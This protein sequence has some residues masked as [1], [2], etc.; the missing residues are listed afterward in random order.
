MNGR[1]RAKTKIGGAFKARNRWRCKR[2]IERTGLEVVIRFLDRTFPG[3][4]LGCPNFPVMVVLFSA[5]RL[6]TTN[7]ATLCDFTGY[8]REYVEAIAE[9]MANNGLWQGD[10]YV[11]FRMVAGRLPR[12]ERV[13]TP[14]RCRAGDA[15]L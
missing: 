14:N 8:S 7:I 4:G 9:N 12:R 6:R 1:C 13:R 5:A 2:C 11:A 10:Q 3:I 15:V